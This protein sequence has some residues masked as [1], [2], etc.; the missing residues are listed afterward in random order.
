MTIFVDLPVG[1][2]VY[3]IV[4]INHDPVDTR[5]AF[6]T[7]AIVKCRWI[8]N[9]SVT[10]MRNTEMLVAYEEMRVLRSTNI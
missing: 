9:M 3:R 10:E 8:D 7:G 5:W 6:S 1:G 4:G 2:D